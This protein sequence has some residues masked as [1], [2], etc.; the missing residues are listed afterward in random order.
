LAPTLPPGLSAL[1]RLQAEARAGVEAALAPPDLA[2][3]LQASQALGYG[4]VCDLLAEAVRAP[5]TF[6]APSQTPAL[7]SL[8][9]AE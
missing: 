8:G 4:D 7:R 1:D 3:L 6:S 2:R 9:P 5:W